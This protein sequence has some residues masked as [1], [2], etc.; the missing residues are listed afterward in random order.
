M[1]SHQKPELIPTQ[2]ELLDEATEKAIASVREKEAQVGTTPSA[3]WGESI[4]LLLLSCDVSAAPLCDAVITWCGR[5]HEAALFC[6][7]YDQQTSRSVC[8]DEVSGEGVGEDHGPSST[9]YPH[10]P[11]RCVTLLHG[12]EPNRSPCRRHTPN[13]KHDALLLLPQAPETVCKRNNNPHHNQCLRAHRR[14][15]RQQQQQH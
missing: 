15:T 14:C 9:P 8:G 2:V 10:L 11:H 13:S 5:A 7:G 1:G 12:C 3:K 6:T 4:P